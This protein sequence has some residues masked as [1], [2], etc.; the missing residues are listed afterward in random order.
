MSYELF[1]SEYNPPPILDQSP[2]TSPTDID[3]PQTS[4]LDI[5]SPQPDNVQLSTPFKIG[6]IT[7]ASILAFIILIMMIMVV[8]SMNK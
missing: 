4:P 3:S 2:Q 1:T 7:V 6:L 8:R 5:D